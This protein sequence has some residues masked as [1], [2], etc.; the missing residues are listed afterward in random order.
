[1]PGL[2]VVMHEWASHASLDGSR[3]F[4]TWNLRIG[5]TCRVS[6]IYPRSMNPQMATRSTE[7]TKEDFVDFVPLVA[8]TPS[9]EECGW[10]A[11][12]N[13]FDIWLTRRPL[14]KM[15][16]ALGKVRNPM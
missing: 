8:S 3:R 4:A 6:Q 11:N 9:S 13:G 7:G 12:F 16:V 5:Q 15:R 10:A 1:M 14:G 2:A